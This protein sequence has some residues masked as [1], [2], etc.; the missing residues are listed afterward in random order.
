MKTQLNK[1]QQHKA[2]ENMGNSSA[3][4]ENSGQAID[5]RPQTIAE[6]ALL[7]QVENSTHLE[8]ATVLQAM[9]NNSLVIKQSQSFQ[10][11]ADAGRTSEPLRV[12]PPIVSPLIQR[13]TGDQEKRFAAIRKMANERGEK[14]KMLAEINTF[15][16]DIKT[17]TSVRANV[18]RTN[19]NRWKVAANRP[20]MSAHLRKTPTHK[21]PD[22]NST[23]RINKPDSFSPNEKAIS[24]ST[25]K[26]P[27]SVVSVPKEEISISP[28]KEELSTIDNLEKEE[29]I[30]QGIPREFIYD[31]HAR[32]ETLLF[33]TNVNKV[34]MR[35]Y[36]TNEISSYFDVDE[37][38]LHETS[39]NILEGLT[40]DE[41]KADYTLSSQSDHLGTFGLKPQPTLG[42]GNCSIHALLGTPNDTG[43]LVCENA[44]EIRRQLAEN[45]SNELLSPEAMELMHAGRNNTIRH[46]S[47]NLLQEHINNEGSSMKVSGKEG[48][49]KEKS[50][51]SG[52]ELSIGE[53]RNNLQWAIH[54][55]N[56]DNYEASIN[57]HITETTFND[58]IEGI[59]GGEILQELV[60]LNVVGDDGTVI[61]PGIKAEELM[62]VLPERMQV[63]ASSIYELLKPYKKGKIDTE[64]FLKSAL[65]KREVHDAYLALLK[66][67]YHWLNAEQL[68]ALAIIHGKSI[69]LFENDFMGGVQKTAPVNVAAEKPIIPIY[70]SGTHFERLVTVDDPGKF[71]DT[72]KVSSG[73]IPE[74]VSPTDVFQQG[75]YNLA[76][77]EYHSPFKNVSNKRK[78]DE[79]YRARR[80]HGLGHGLRISASV[81]K[82]VNTISQSSSLQIKFSTDQDHLAA[83]SMAAL[84]HDAANMREDDKLAE[85]KQGQLFEEKFRENSK[86]MPIEGIKEEAYKWAIRCLKLKGTVSISKKKWNDMTSEEQ[87]AALIAGADSYEYVRSYP[88]MK[89]SYKRDRNILFSS[90]AM[91]KSKDSEHFDAVMKLIL[92]T[93]GNTGGAKT[94]V[95]NPAELASYF[96][97]H[98][99]EAVKKSDSLL[100]AAFAEFAN[101]GTQAGPV[102]ILGILNT[103]SGPS[104]TSRATAPSSK[105]RLEKKNVLLKKKITISVIRTSDAKKDSSASTKRRL[106]NFY[107]RSSSGTR[108]T[109]TIPKEGTFFK[110]GKTPEF[111]SANKPG[112]PKEVD[113]E[114][115]LA[116]VHGISSEYIPGAFK[117]GFL[118]SAYMRE[119][120]YGNYSRDADR[121]GGGGLAVYTRAVGKKHIKWPAHGYG[122]GSG[123]KKAQIVLHPKI[124]ASDMVWRHSSTDLMGN[125]PGGE[126]AKKL[127]TARTLDTFDLWQQQTESGRNSAFNSAIN[128][129]SPEGV[130]NNEQMFWERIPLPS[131]VIAIICKSEEDKRRLIEN[132]GGKAEDGYILY[133]GEKIPVIVAGD[134]DTLAAVLEQI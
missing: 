80:A 10:A 70:S 77:E 28:G 65:E 50:E 113:A 11:M 34:M 110:Q 87:G 2:P 21:L 8:H 74:D 19:L 128:Q 75:M 69:Q 62:G 123:D 66:H 59:S 20:S 82:L 127:D 134:D 61:N 55:A 6:R 89:G 41:G 58:V 85:G 32:A 100:H 7:A 108:I 131:N 31:L 42:D 99:I 71:A 111:R 83:L 27:E 112:K 81:L 72:G 63:K 125:A 114:N 1:T 51:E 23:A 86:S 39:S 47:Y 12:V 84:W 103:F 46:V 68:E 133:H 30:I 22:K 29:D 43:T 101:T 122:V 25:V 105:K 90:G 124:L 132:M 92:D 45:Y 44:Q 56:A 102:D 121:L 97:Y 16:E 36:I 67:Q 106:I 119:G 95:E 13:V 49:D 91:D 126:A 93:A 57:K 60:K 118:S 14:T 76:R 54:A 115:A 129:D 88:D 98:G 73:E 94:S 38:V 9:A 17:D 107:P 24:S 79:K 18:M 33:F 3:I 120:P 48:T 35:E 53:L 15:L 37:K 78:T 96:E 104:P 5:N 52:K 130:S 26:K 109:K 4:T 64:L 117:S 116:L 40:F